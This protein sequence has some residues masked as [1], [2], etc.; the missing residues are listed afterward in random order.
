M[1]KVVF[2]LSLIIFSK[3]TLA[4]VNFDSLKYVK[5]ADGSEYKIYKALNGTVIKYGNFLEMNA[6]ALYN[7]SLLFSSIADGMPQYAMYDTA[8]FP[9]PYK[10]AF[11]NLHTGDSVVIRISTDSLIAKGQAAGAPFIKKGQFIYQAY[12]LTNIYTTREQADSAQKT[13]VKA[14]KEIAYKKQ[15][16]AIATDLINNKEQ[17]EKD[18]KVIEAFLSKNKMKYTKADWG[19][20]IVIKAEGTG[21]KITK[22]DVAS[23]N[24]TGKSFSN[25]KVFDS[26]TDP[27]FKHVQPLDVNMGQLGSIILGW[28]DALYQIKKGTKATL[29]IPSSLG[30]GKNGNPGAGINPDEILVFDMQIGNVL[31]EEKMELIQTAKEQ[32]RKKIKEIKLA[33]KLKKAPLKSKTK[34]GKIITK[35]K[36]ALK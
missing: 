26:N 2:F 11:A 1:R 36:K 25:K 30:Y 21:E 32:V 9:N 19:T 22:G 16:D 3:L 8:A 13:H 27:K 35:T 14:A 24:Y 20:Y 10:Q 33:D 31:S 34:P 29:Y 7:D 6:I 18:S 28:I 23:V 5:T 17:I 15:K 4:Q 12:T